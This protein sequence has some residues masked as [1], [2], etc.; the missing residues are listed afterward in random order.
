MRRT[1]IV[2]TLGP[3]VDDPET[4]TALVNAGLD[5]ARL[6]FSHGTFPEHEARCHAVRRAA[7]KAGRPVAV[8]QDL[9]GPKIRVGT[10]AEGTRLRKDALLT[11]TSEP[12]VG[13]EE[14]VHLPVPALFV[15]VK[16]GHRLLLDDG[17]L[18]LVVLENDGANILTRV[19]FGGVLGSKKGVSAPEAH[20][21]IPAVT[22]KDIADV[23]FGLALGVDF[24]A[25]SFVQHAGDIA[26]LR[27]VMEAEG[28]FAPIIAKIEMPEAVNNLDAIL[29]ACDGA[30]VARGDLGVEMPVEEVPRVQKQ[31]I[32]A[33]NHR[34]KPVITAT[35]MLDSMIRN[36]RPTRAEVTD[37]ANAV[38]DGTDAVMLSGET[39]VGAY[40]VEA[41]ETMARIACRAE[42]E[43]M[44]YSGVFEQTRK[45]FGKDNLADALAEAVATI[46]HDR[47]AAAI[48][49]STS[50]GGTARTLSKFK[51]R[52]PILAATSSDKAE[53]QMV[54]SWGVCPMRVRY[55]ADTDE[56]IQ[57][58]VEAA[59]LAGHV[60][61][62]DLVVITAGTPVGTVGSTNL[63]KVHTVGNPLTQPATP[64]K[65]EASI[66]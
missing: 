38:L 59:V 22:E 1:K 63:I 46:A 3:A 19:V 23:R 58:A 32:R 8:L 45:A 2:C 28:R 41:V 16:P 6:N 11:L 27:R 54:M 30:M 60:K 57:N 47:Q 37:I 64:P 12:V 35:Q 13:N 56:M 14:R 18:E 65:P 26:I 33:C 62:G 52:A 10:V 7:E 20:L 21:D 15:A 53:K 48:I 49:C 34:G 24:V 39:A 36:P 31:I 17:N 66:L 44:D 43:M 51:P 61:N 29:D 40:P 4:L 55:P 25:L 9:C 50:S 5:I 42:D